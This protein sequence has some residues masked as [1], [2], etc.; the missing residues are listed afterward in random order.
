MHYILAS[1]SS[2]PTIAVGIG[3]L[4]W[5]PDVE[6]ILAELTQS[7]FD[8]FKAMIE[9]YVKRIYGLDDIVFFGVR[10]ARGSVCK[11]D[12]K[13][14]ID[15]RGLRDAMRDYEKYFGKTEEWN[16]LMY[17]DDGSFTVISNYEIIED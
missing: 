14:H 8:K 5:K 15:F 1:K 12:V 17:L 6:A 9:N 2:E 16:T 11:S 10:E 7:E 3:R 13:P 4:I